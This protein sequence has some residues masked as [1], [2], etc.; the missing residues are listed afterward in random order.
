[1]RRLKLWL[2]TAGALALVVTG[3]AVAHGKRDRT[4]TDS[5]SATLT[6]TQSSVRNKTCTGTDGAYTKFHGTWTGT[7]TGNGRLS[8]ALKVHGSG[9]INTDTGVGQ[10]T[11][12]LRIRGEKNGAKA[13][14]WATYRGGTL[15]GFV[16]GWVHDKTGSTVE[17]QAGS[18]RLL[19]S[20]SGTLAPNGALAGQIGG[21]P[22]A[23]PAT[24]QAGGCWS[25][26]HR[27]RRG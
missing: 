19:G 9:L 17:E 26:E 21:A 22:A 11:G 20:F 15:G 16:N 14:F 10:V 4:H 5:V 23:G 24:I 3:A 2:L 8:G 6:A 13:R 1:M 12:W 7:A 18:G 25:G 27:K